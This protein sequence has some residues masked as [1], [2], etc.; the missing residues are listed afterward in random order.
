MPLV[1]LNKSVEVDHFV[2][3]GIL[4]VPVTFGSRLARKYAMQVAIK[5]LSV[6]VDLQLLLLV[7]WRMPFVSRARGVWLLWVDRLRTNGDGRM[8]ILEQLRFIIVI[9]RSR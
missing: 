5:L 8:K 3:I 7:L 6:S 9:L 2:T 4:V 1:L